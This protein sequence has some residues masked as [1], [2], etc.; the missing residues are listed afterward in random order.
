MNILIVI[1]GPLSISSRYGV[2]TPKELMKDVKNLN[3]PNEIITVMKEIQSRLVN[4]NVIIHWL[5]PAGL[6]WDVF[7]KKADLL[8]AN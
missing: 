7:Q 8:I 6:L 2:I 1:A 5:K 4:G 3:D